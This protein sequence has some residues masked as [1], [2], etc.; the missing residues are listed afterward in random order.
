MNYSI[1]IKGG[2]K[3]IKYKAISIYLICKYNLILLIFF[4]YV[5]NWYHFIFEIKKDLKILNDKCLS[6]FYLLN[7]D[8]ESD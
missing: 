6:P 5:R 3:F 4:I 1:N 2:Y 7:A 8:N